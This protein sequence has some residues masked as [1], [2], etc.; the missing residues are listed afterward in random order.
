MACPANMKQT[1]VVRQEFMDAAVKWLSCKMEK[2]VDNSLEVCESI[3]PE[4]AP[5]TIFI[6]TEL[7]TCKQER[8]SLK[9]EVVDWQHEPQAV[10]SVFLAD[11][12]KNDAESPDFD[13]HSTLQE[14]GDS[15]EEGNS[16]AAND[17]SFEPQRSD[18]VPEVIKSS[19][20]TSKDKGVEKQ[21]ESLDRLVAQKFKCKLCGY[22]CTGVSNLKRHRRLKHKVRESSKCKFDPNSCDEEAVLRLQDQE[23]DLG[24][25]VK[26]PQCNETCSSRLELKA[27]KAAKHGVGVRFEPLRT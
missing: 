3:S 19:G 9:E 1:V 7:P 26:C 6:K 25:Q 14:P 24:S 13:T 22:V 12:C 2:E 15:L 17:L 16:G 21:S 20:E 10:E 27:H 23:H 5:D 8:I 11:P 4:T 18:L